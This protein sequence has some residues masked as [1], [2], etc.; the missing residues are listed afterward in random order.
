MPA[1]IF[2]RI[3]S[4]GFLNFFAWGYFVMYELKSEQ[5]GFFEIVFVV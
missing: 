3:Y 2:L 5:A 1:G 4:V